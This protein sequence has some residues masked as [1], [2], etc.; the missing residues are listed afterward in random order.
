M[1]FSQTTFISN[2]FYLLAGKAKHILCFRN[3]SVHQVVT[4][5]YTKLLPEH[6][7]QIVFTDKKMLCQKI[8]AYFLLIM[9][10]QVLLYRKYIL[11][12]QLC[13]PV[14]LRRMPGLIHQ[15][16]QQIIQ[17]T[18]N[19]HIPDIIIGICQLINPAINFQK[20]GNG[21]GVE[22]CSSTPL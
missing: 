8:Q 4:D 19:L 9:L 1:R 2:V 7:S 17:L 18:V 22:D 5:T 14:L 10:I 11:F 6:A 12:F 15:K 21:N 16:C 13:I 3:S 20:P